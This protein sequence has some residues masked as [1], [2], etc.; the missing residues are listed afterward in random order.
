MTHKTV[1]KKTSFLPTLKSRK[2]FLLVARKGEK[3]VAKSFIL[4]ALPFENPSQSAEIGYTVSKKVGKAVVRN[5]V[6]RRLREAFKIAFEKNQ[7]LPYRY[8]VIARSECPHVTF[9]A[10][11]KELSWSLKHLHRLVTKKTSD[12]G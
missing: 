3:W 7:V 10:L 8:V 4:Q 9:Q 5:K 11:Q 1:K 2:D 6:K 12:I